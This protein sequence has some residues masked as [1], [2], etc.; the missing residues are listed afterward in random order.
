[1]KLITRIAI[2]V[3]SVASLSYLIYYVVEN[4][5]E[6]AVGDETA[7]YR[8]KVP[9]DK[10]DL[11]CLWTIRLKSGVRFGQCYK[12]NSRAEGKEDYMMGSNIEYTATKIE[13]SFCE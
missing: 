12:T 6:K 9:D 4:D 11:I 8:V 5:F 10:V 13:K 2:S 1:M 3:I 7:C